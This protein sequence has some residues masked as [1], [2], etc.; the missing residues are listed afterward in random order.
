[1]VKKCARTE[2]DFEAHCPGN[3]F[4]G[5]WVLSK[6]TVFTPIEKTGTKKVV[7]W[8]DLR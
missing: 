3:R 8:E 6:T 1:M 4:A 2:V 5:R 7:S